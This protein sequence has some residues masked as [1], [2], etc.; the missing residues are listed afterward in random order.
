MEGDRFRFETEI[1]TTGRGYRTRTPASPSFPFT[2]LRVRTGSRGFPSNSEGTV[3]TKLQIERGIGRG[4]RAESVLEE[5]VKRGQTAI[6][7]EAHVL[8]SEKVRTP[9]RKAYDQL[10]DRQR[11]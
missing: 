5:R 7:I 8:E 11:Y 6:V 2:S 10:R 1:T 3:G 4:R 9:G